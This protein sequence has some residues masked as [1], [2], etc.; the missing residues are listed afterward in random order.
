MGLEDLAGKVAILDFWATWCSP[1]HV[2]AEILEEVMEEFGG[3]DLEIVS[4]DSGEEAE[5]VRAFV[6]KNPKPFAVL[7]DADNA[8][9]DEYRVAALPTLV[10]LDRRGRIAFT[11]VG[12]TEANELR[13]LIRAE[14]A[15]AA[16]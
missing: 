9:S 11:S 7:I 2:Q 15:R 14:L 4:I 12:I 1:C 5:R 10:L 3:E 8:V 16:G 6:E 13:P